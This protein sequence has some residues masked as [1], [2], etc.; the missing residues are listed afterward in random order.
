VGLTIIENAACFDGSAA[1]LTEPLHVAIEGDRIREVSDR[2]IA[3]PA[4]RRIDARGKTLMPGMIDAHVHVYAAELN[5][6]R[7]SRRP[8]TYLAHYAATFLRHMLHCGYTTVRDTGG[9]DYG[10]A[11]ALRD[12]LVEGPTL[13]YGNQLLSQLG[14]H[15]DWRSPEE[16]DHACSLCGCGSIDQKLAIIA[17]GVDGVVRATREQL[18]RG[19]HHIKILASGG[20]ASPSDPLDAIQYSPAE[21]TAIVEECARHGK[22]VAAHCHPDAAVRRC[23]ELGVRSIEHATLIEPDTARF[24]AKSDAFLVPTMAVIFALDKDGAALGLPPASVAKLRQITRRAVEGLAIMKDAGCR[25]GFGTDLLG[26]HHDRQG[27]EF[28]I[29]REVFSAAEIL[30]QATSTNAALL[31]AENELGCVKPEARADLLLVDGNPLEN[32]DLLA[33]NGAHLSMV[34]HRGVPKRLSV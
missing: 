1:E 7:V 13:Y 22:Y 14:G 17:D 27:I 29:R 25:I 5:L 6:T 20:V 23:V 4:D 9:G 18:R 31:S 19:A 34:M 33:A 21:I 10:L 28:G 26:P 8:W 32:L 3:G 11:G 15:A 12:G 16:D 24:V 2:P 30:R